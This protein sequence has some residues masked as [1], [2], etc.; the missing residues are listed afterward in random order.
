MHKEKPPLD[1]GEIEK[2]WLPEKGE[3]L[4]KASQAVVCMN[5]LINHYRNNGY[6]FT[7]TLPNLQ[8][9]SQTYD[10]SCYANWLIAHIPETEWE[11]DKIRF[12]KTGEQ[13]IDLLCS[14][15]DNQLKR[16][17]PTL[18]LEVAEDSIYNFKG[19]YINREY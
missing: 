13:Y 9:L 10:I 2:K 3:G 16:I 5:L 15:R 1:W 18:K 7:N 14:I 11:F 4:T 17:V 19:K 6:Y 8:N 12:C